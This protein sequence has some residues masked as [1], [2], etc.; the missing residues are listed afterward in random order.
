MNWL[1][2]SAGHVIVGIAEGGKT[3]YTARVLRWTVAGREAHEKMA[4][5]RAGA[6]ASTRL[7]RL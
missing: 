6:S 2:A 5:I 7:R 1:P 4:S 3:K